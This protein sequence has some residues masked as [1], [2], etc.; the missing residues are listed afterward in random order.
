MRRLIITLTVVVFAAISSS[1]ASA[2]LLCKKNA[3]CDSAPVCCEAPAP[4]CDATPACRP[5]LQLGHKLK[6]MKGHL[7][8]KFQ[9][10]SSC[11]TAPSCGCEAAAPCAVAAAPC[12]APAPSCGCE[13]APSGGCDAAAS[14]GKPARKHCLKGMFTHMKGKFASKKCGAAASS[15]DGGASAPS[16]GCEAPAPSCGCN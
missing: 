9:R 1:N 3:G 12:A 6:G 11:D 14:C 7:Q 13:A 16:C 10:N 15:C 2:G 8:G 5:K 4:S